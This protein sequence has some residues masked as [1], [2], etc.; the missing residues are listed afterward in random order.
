MNAG[1]V[2]LAGRLA[3]RKIRGAPPMS[4]KVKNA[5][6]WGFVWGIASTIL[7]RFA[8][9]LTGWPVL[10][11]ELRGVLKRA[12]GTR[13]DYGVLG[14]RVVTDVF[15]DDLVDELQ[16]YTGIDGYQYHDS[17]E[18]NTAE[19]TTDT[20]IETT[21]GES[22]ASGT[23]T[24]GGSTNVYQSVGTISY[25]SS[26]AIT[27]HGLFNASTGGTLMDRTV[28]SAINV[29]SGDSIEFTYELTVSAGG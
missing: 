19:A 5:L 14:R 13:V 3:T 27:E 17:G 7:A 25:T 6:R 21:D 8:G 20:D 15:V 28:F 24:E 16:S 2:V 9:R 29:S 12:D 22:R 1:K 4:W 23:Q 10:T 18:G 26:K 11:S